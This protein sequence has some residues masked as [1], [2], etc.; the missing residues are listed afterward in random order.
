MNPFALAVVAVIFGGIIFSLA[1][2]ILFS[3]VMAVVIAAVFAIGALESPLVISP[4]T[5]DLAF[6]PVHL[7]EPGYLYTLFTSMFLHATFFHLIFNM[8]AL[9]FIGPLLEEKIGTVRFAAIYVTTGLIG[10]LAYGLM[11]LNEIA[12]VLGASGAI[13]GILGAFAVLYPREKI[14]M[15]YMFIPLPPMRIPYLVA[16]IVVIETLFAFDPRSHTAHEAHLAGLAAG[17]L[18][19]PLIMRIGLPSKEEVT[20]AG[21][22]Q[23]AV[24]DE[25]RIILQKIEGESLEDV[26][27][28]WLERFLQKARCPECGDIVRMKGRKIY[29]E[30]G[31][32]IRI[33]RKE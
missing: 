23:L 13:S 6:Q 26:R 30:C 28:A 27:R 18:I 12:I 15:L 5:L 2:K 9:I 8:I 21:L 33:E 16:F 11:H 20:L 25:L 7:R 32:S 10:T 3:L 14:S 31:W 4:M 19:A 29:S 22:E 24:N 1:R 17:I